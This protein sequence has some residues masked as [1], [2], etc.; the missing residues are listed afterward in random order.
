MKS[1][2]NKISS[3]TIRN[4]FIKADLQINCNI[5]ANE[6]NTQTKVDEVNVSELSELLKK[7][8]I[9][10]TSEEFID[11]IMMDD[12][13]SPEYIISA[14]LEE[15]NPFLEE[16]E[17]STADNQQVGETS[18]M[19]SALCSYESVCEDDTL[20]ASSN[21]VDYPIQD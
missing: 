16:L 1:A 2:L 8:Q 12:E 18:G 15:S 21:C 17:D 5:E 13:N 9:S 14:I 20:S 11:F 6:T 19:A 3:T 7:L 10:L 4:A